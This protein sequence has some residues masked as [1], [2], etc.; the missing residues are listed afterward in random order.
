MTTKRSLRN[1]RLLATGS[2]LSTLGAAALI[3]AL[4]FEPAYTSGPFAFPIG[5][6]NGIIMG[7]GATLALWNLKP[8]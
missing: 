3:F 8:S 6:G 5:V 2:I 4:I 7:L 1:R